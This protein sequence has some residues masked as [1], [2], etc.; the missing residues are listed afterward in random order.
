MSSLAGMVF[1]ADDRTFEECLNRL[2]FGLPIYW[3]DA[4]RH[5][6]KGMP[7]FLFDSKARQMYGV[8]VATS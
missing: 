7:V 8:F 1:M 5:V 3:I 4:V 2:L 6:Q